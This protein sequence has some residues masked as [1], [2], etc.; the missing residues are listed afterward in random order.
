MSEPVQIEAHPAHKT[1]LDITDVSHDRPTVFVGGFPKSANTQV[2]NEFVKTIC[3]HTD[4]MLVTDSKYRSRGFVFITFATYKE[5]KLFVSRDHIFD[6]KVLDCKISLDH[7]EFITASLNNI[8]APKKIFVDKIPKRFKKR[9][10]EK[11]FGVYGEIEEV[12]LIEKDERK[13]NFGY[14][15][16]YKAEAAKKC[17]S[18]RIFDVG[19]DLKMSAIFA[20]PKF[21]KKMLIGI[22][23]V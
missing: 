20:R 22:H 15:T 12:I 3:N 1:T 19:E 10:L 4:F 5:A 2:I 8:R 6:G 7:E 9:D 11:L 13:I 16:Y 14:V 23:P 17:V 21:S 18:Q